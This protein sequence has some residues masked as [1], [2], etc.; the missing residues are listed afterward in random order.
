MYNLQVLTNVSPNN[1]NTN[2]VNLAS[3]RLG[4]LQLEIKLVDISCTHQAVLKNTSIKNSIA[5]S[6]C[7]PLKHMQ[8]TIDMFNGPKFCLLKPNV[9]GQN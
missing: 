8:K 2:Q 1:A 6:C 9:A 3:Q 5:I 7:F 4:V